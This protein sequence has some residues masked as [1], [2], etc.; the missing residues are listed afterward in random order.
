MV[1]KSPRSGP[2]SLCIGSI[3]HTRSHT[4]KKTNF[5]IATAELIVATK[6]SAETSFPLG[7]TDWLPHH[8]AM[9]RQPISSPPIITVTVAILVL[10][11]F[12]SRRRRRRTCAPPRSRWRPPTRPRPRRS[13]SPADPGHHGADSPFFNPS[14]SPA[15][16]RHLGFFFLPICCL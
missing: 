1:C 8:T 11:I 6:T 16:L 4:S 15:L 9:N 14:L 2:K 3:Q 13:A 7:P 12:P 5:K 10:R